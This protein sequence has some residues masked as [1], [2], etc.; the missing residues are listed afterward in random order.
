[1]Q[2]V[3]LPEHVTLTRLTLRPC[4]PGNSISL[5]PTVSKEGRE[6]RRN[7]DTHGSDYVRYLSA[8]RTWSTLHH[9]SRFSKGGTKNV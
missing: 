8:P 5:H 7:D 4:I 1:M 2:M 3:Q 9:F 6:A